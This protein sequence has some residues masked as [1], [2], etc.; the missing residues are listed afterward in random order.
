[1]VLLFPPSETMS[2]PCRPRRRNSSCGGKNRCCFTSCPDEVGASCD[3]RLGEIRTTSF[4]EKDEALRRVTAQLKLLHMPSDD[5]LRSAPR[6]DLFVRRT[7]EPGLMPSTRS[8]F[9]KSRRDLCTLRSFWEQAPARVPENLVKTSVV[10]KEQQWSGGG[11][12][13]G[14]RM[15]FYVQ[16]EPFPHVFR[17]E[18][19]WTTSSRRD[20]AEE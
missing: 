12:A 20:A 1:M 2:S 6:H 7:I 8:T 18:A 4:F 17:M 3:G 13:A 14:S 9:K 10:G 15:I 19:P 5:L 11:V 16:T